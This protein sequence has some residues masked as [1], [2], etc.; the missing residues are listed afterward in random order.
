[1]D[2]D[3]RGIVLHMIGRSG[4]LSAN[5]I[6]KTVVSIGCGDCAGRQ[7]HGRSPDHDRIGTSDM[8]ILRCYKSAWL[9][10]VL[11][12]SP[13]YL[14]PFLSIRRCCGGCTAAL[15]G[16]YTRAQRQHAQRDKNHGLHRKFSRNRTEYPALADQ[17][18]LRPTESMRHNMFDGAGWDIWGDEI[19]PL[20]TQPL[21]ITR[22]V[23]AESEFRAFVAI[24]YQNVLRAVLR[25]LQPVPRQLLVE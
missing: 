24:R 10:G 9:F 18:G 1:V 11:A 21:P 14:G 8:S 4:D 17:M 16:G 3:T 19:G 25:H 13:L 15:C 6:S 23:P 20:V 12:L 22:T 7:A 5:G 2:L